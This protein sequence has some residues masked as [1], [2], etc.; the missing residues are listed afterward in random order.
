[1][2]VYEPLRPNMRNSTKIGMIAMIGGGLALVAG[3]L[4]RWAAL[5]LAV[6]SVVAALIFHHNFG[7]QN[8]MIRRLLQCLEQRIGGLFV[9]PVEMIDQKNPA[10]AVQRLELGTLLE[11][12]HLR[13]GELAQRPVGRERHEIGMRGE[14]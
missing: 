12:A 2:P 8:Q 13:D 6:Y 10:R 3:F 11:Q 1:M 9:G 7:N 4:T 5:T 14:Q